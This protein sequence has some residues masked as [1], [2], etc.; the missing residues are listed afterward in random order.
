[1]T[2]KNIKAQ[3]RRV[4]AIVE[5][6]HPYSI[7]VALSGCS[8][9]LEAVAAS[10]SPSDVKLGKTHFLLLLLYSCSLISLAIT[11][12]ILRLSPRH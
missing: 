1:M 12:T 11:C 10:V 4:A 9:G 6:C 5:S 3:G 2:L 7:N 8:E